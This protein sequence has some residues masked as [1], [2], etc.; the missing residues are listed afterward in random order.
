MAFKLLR[1]PNFIPAEWLL[2]QHQH[3]LGGVP[4][5]PLQS[6]YDEHMSTI[7]PNHIPTHQYLLRATLLSM[8][9]NEQTIHQ[10]Q[11]AQNERWQAIFDQQPDGRLHV[12][13]ASNIGLSSSTNP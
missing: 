10:F 9:A 11:A 1:D 12:L 3:T 6:T 5:A 13:G 2:H 4:S 8:G 7:H